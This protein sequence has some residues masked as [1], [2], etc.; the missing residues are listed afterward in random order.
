MGVQ[1]P[2]GRGNFEGAFP[3]MPD[4]IAVRCAKTAQPMG[5]M[6]SSEPKEAFYMGAY[7]RH[8][9]HT[10]K[11]SVSGGDAAF[12]SQ[13]FDHLLN[14]VSMLHNV[15][16]LRACA[17]K[18]VI[19]RKRRATVTLLLIGSGLPH[20]VISGIGQCPTAL[21]GHSSITTF[22]NLYSPEKVYGSEKRNKHSANLTNI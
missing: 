15:S 19:S 5:Y 7:W 11:P 8:L 21:D 10:I 20:S 3:D 9:A 16:R 12:L 22:K 17:V 14:V 6:D 18:V 2:L 13:Y 4:D 1:I